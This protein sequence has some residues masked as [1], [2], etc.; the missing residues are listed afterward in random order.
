MKS[1]CVVTGT[2]AEYHLLYPLLKR[3]QEDEHYRLLL[4]VTGTHLHP[5]YGETY[6][7][8][9]K[10]L[11][12]I[13]VKIPILT[14]TGTES[15]INAAMSKVLIGL[16]QFFS[17]ECIDLLILLGDRYE[18]LS[19][20]IV[21]M[22]YRVPIA[23]IACGD[24]TEGAIDE[25]IRHS[26]TKMASLHFSF[27]EAYR[28]RVIQMGENPIHVFNTGSLAIENIKNT[29]LLTREQLEDSLQFDLSGQFGVVTFHPVTLEEDT[30]EVEFK[31]L[32]HALEQEK[33]LKIIFTKSNADKGGMRINEMI[34][35]FVSQNQNRTVAVFSLGLQRYLSALAMADIVI[36]NSSSGIYETPSFGVPTVNIG[37]RQ[38]GRIQAKNIINCRPDSGEII[39]AMKRG[40]SASFRESVKDTQNPYGDGNASIRIMEKIDYFFAN[41]ELF[42]LK[43]QFYDIDF[44]TK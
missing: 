8:I 14:E 22:N 28:K 30:F 44:E 10:D 13:A 18:L 34:D 12:S 15:D 19:A 39:N 31:N 42:P 37:D 38:K 33:E 20:A 35:A 43:K 16:D 9:E 3:I 21:A 11:I 7:D 5:K 36:G 32:L 29:R 25:C 41:P 40:L 17:K 23:H 27:C 1:I 2:R 4:A 6:R 24:T 26:I